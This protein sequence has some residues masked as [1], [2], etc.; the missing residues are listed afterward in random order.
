MSENADIS[1][2]LLFPVPETLSPRIAWIQRHG[3]KTF[4][5]TGQPPEEYPWAA[6][7]MSDEVGGLPR[8]DSYAT[9]ATEHDAIAE[10]ARFKGL[11]LWN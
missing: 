1:P 10:L 3:V 9:G 6:W 7:L 5:S 8:F 2:D 11:K 4:H